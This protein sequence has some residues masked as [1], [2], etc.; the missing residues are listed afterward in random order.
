MCVSKKQRKKIE[1]EFSVLPELE[2]R[3][4]EEKTGYDKFCDTQVIQ[5]QCIYE[6]K[7][8]RVLHDY[9][10]I[11][12]TKDGLH[13]LLVTKRHCV[14]SS[15]LTFSEFKEKFDLKQKLIKHFKEK[16][17]T[18]VHNFEKNGWLQ[19]VPHNH[20]HLVFGEKEPVTFLEKVGTVPK[21][22]WRTRL[23]NLKER[24][25]VLSKELF[26]VLKK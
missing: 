26:D 11:S 13:L 20:E 7:E 2:N 6:G 15:E 1:E 14:A 12:L 21:L 10:P 5:N 25:E 4:I 3:T 9:A 24:V 18:V 8:I 17:C 22:A 16:G 23:P 19:S